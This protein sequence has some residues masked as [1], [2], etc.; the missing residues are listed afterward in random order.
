MDEPC[1]SLFVFIGRRYASIVERD[2]AFV[3]RG[4][5]RP[6]KQASARGQGA[7]VLYTIKRAA[8]P[9]FLA[10][11][12]AIR[13]GSRQASDKP[14]LHPAHRF[15]VSGNALTHASPMARGVRC[16]APRG[17]A[18]VRA[19]SRRMPAGRIRE[20]TLALPVLAVGVLS[21]SLAR[22]FRGGGARVLAG[23]APH[24]ATS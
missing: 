12:M 19:K 24:R 9:R 22:R 16:V 23:P 7:A 20:R 15:R 11:S 6:L 5:T 4:A 14:V 10:M 18:V 2:Q 8:W 1:A 3:F 21:K 17:P 13:S